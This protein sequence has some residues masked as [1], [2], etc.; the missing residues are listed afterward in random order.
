MRLLC[1]ARRLY[2]PRRLASKHIIGS[3]APQP[4]SLFAPKPELKRHFFGAFRQP[5]V[6]TCHTTPAKPPFFSSGNSTCYEIIN[7]DNYV[8]TLR[9][10]SQLDVSQFVGII[11]K[12]ND[13]G[14]GDEAMLFLDECCV[15]PNKDLVFLVIWELRDQWKLAYLLFKWGEKCKCLEENTW[16][17]MIWILGNHGKFSTAWSLIRDLLQMSTNIQE[18]VL[19]MIDRYA[20][21]NNAGKAIQTFQIMEKFSMSPDQ[22][23]LLT[24]LN[25]LCKHGFIEEAEEFMFINKK[26]FPLEIDGFNIILNGWCNIMVD[27]F[28]A[29]R[30]WRE[31]SKCCIEPNGTSYTHMISCF[32]KVRN[33]FDSLRLYD[34][35]QKRGWVPSL[36]VYNSL[37]YVLTCENCVKEALKILDKVKHIGLRPDSSTYNL[38]IRPLCESS[39]LGEARSIL[40]LMEE[41]NISPTIET[42]HAFL[43]GASLE[44]T[45]EVLNSMKRAEVG[46]NRDT[47]LL[48][49]DSFLKL[50]QPENALKIWAEMKQYEVVPQSAHYSLLVGGLVESRLFSQARELYSEMKSGG[51]LDD[52]GLLKF[53]ELPTGPRGQRDVRDPKH[54]KKGKPSKHPVHRVIRSEKGRR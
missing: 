1:L 38:M 15:K 53:L 44:G 37:I 10:K 40:A 24:F 3:I 21:A 30:I 26:L 29:K 2:N 9:E 52:P 36:E 25:T 54:T 31:M 23:I 5:F 16:C 14:S 8:D 20:A 28:E 7:F 43:A 27:V 39:K 48:I 18:A 22:R 46:P 49:L 13:F 11:Q 33:L 19:V 6:R 51:I 45:I 4:P 35:M 17:L 12:A 42:Y 32:S 34:E 41:D 50:K 47:F